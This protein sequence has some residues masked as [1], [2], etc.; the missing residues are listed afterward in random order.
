[1][2]RQ[3]IVM[4]CLEIKSYLGNVL[5]INPMYNTPMEKNFLGFHYMGANHLILIF[6]HLITIG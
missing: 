3:N 2:R 4:H 5:L 6:N 1:M